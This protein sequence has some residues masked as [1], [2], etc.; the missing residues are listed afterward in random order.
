MA[1][2]SARGSVVLWRIEKIRENDALS[3]EEKERNLLVVE[4]YYAFRSDGHLLSKR[5]VN[6]KPE[7]WDLDAQKK[8]YKRLDFGWKDVGK[9][10]NLTWF[11]KN[12]DKTVD[13][14]KE[15]MIKRGWK[16]G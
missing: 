3:R 4:D 12:P 8:G 2:L 13:D 16:I 10:D 1:K 14:W 15:E 9:K 11:K 5:I 7:S 6:F